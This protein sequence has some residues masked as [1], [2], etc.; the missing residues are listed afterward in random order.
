MT[1]QLLNC[2]GLVKRFGDVLAVDRADMRIDRGEFVTLLGPS[3]CGKSTTL[4]LVAGFERPDAGK[5]RIKDHV[6]AD[7]GRHVPPE[8]RRLGMVFQDYALFPHLSVLDNVAFG[9]RGDRK[10]RHRRAQEM[11]EMVGLAY[12]DRRMPYQLSG[13]QQQ[14]VALAR[15]L[16]PAPDMVLLDEPFSNLDA[17]LREQLRGEVRAILKQTGT[18]CLFV[19][20]DQE[21]ALSLSD[22]VAVMFDGRV[23]QMDTPS[24]V[25]RA[26][27]DRH[28][29]SFVGEGNYLQA[30]AVGERA[31]CVLGDVVLQQ[32]K[33]GA[34][35]LMLRPEALSLSP[36]TA[37]AGTTGAGRVLWREYYGHDQRV[38]VKLENGITLVARLGAVEDCEPGADVTVRV[39]GS[40][41]AF[42][43]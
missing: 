13:G 19:T 16:A 14:R 9:L 10:S 30:R 29:A 7:E 42:P 23:V 15:A 22:R 24:A 3:G 1:T 2:S 27:I 31:S 26:P 8:E 17:A 39:T 28:V 21:E 25:Y 40:G 38:G 34:V 37:D 11:L 35:M 18:T 33:Q 5:I 32:P 12:Y 36:L 41:V 43:L 6:V 20:H 4:R